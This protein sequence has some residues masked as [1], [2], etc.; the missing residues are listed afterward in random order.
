MRHA[1]YMAIDVIR[2]RAEYDENTANP[3]PFIERADTEGKPR[4]EFID[5]K[6]T[7][8]NENQNQ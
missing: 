6:T 3:L 7:R 1:I 4:R 5:F 2:E 8:Y